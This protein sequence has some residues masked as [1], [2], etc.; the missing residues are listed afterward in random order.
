MIAMKSRPWG[1]DFIFGRLDQ[2]AR[3]KLDDG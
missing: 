3:R 1:R 2:F